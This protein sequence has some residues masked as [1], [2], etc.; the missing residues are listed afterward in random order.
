MFVDVGANIGLFSLVASGIVGKTGMVYSFEPFNTNHEKL[1]QHIELNNTRNIVLE[2]LA[3]SDNEKIIPLSINEKDK[4]A[5]STRRSECCKN[6]PAKSPARVKLSTRFWALSGTTHQLNTPLGVRLLVAILPRGLEGLVQAEL[7][8]ISEFVTV[9][10]AGDSF[11][12]V[13]IPDK[14]KDFAQPS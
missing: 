3:I 10:A 4:P 6:L 12:R 9:G 8:Q 13:F 1:L 11:A 2:K 7:K 5:G 14:G